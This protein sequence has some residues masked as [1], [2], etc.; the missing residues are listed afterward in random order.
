MMQSVVQIVLLRYEIDTARVPG[1]TAQNSAQSQPAT[2]N[3]AVALQGRLRVTGTTGIK[4]ATRSQQ[5]TQHHLI[6]TDDQ[7]QDFTHRF[8]TLAQCA[9]IAVVNSR[10]LA[11]SAPSRFI[12]TTSSPANN[13]W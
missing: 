10:L 8:A 13:D 6:A 4:T 5:R 1:M 12:T 11:L 7:N 2:S 3:N 9:S